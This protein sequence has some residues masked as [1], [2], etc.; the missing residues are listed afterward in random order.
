MAAMAHL[1]METG[2]GRATKASAPPTSRERAR[3]ERS[4]VSVGGRTAVVKNTSSALVLDG[5]NVLPRVE[6]IVDS[7]GL[8]SLATW[9]RGAIRSPVVAMLFVAVEGALALSP[10]HRVHETT[11]SDLFASSWIMADEMVPSQ[12][13]LSTVDSSWLSRRQGAWPWWPTGG[14]AHGRVDPARRARR[15]A[16]PGALGLP[17]CGDCVGG[18]PDHTPC[19]GSPPMQRVDSTACK[20]ADHASPNDPLTHPT[21]TRAAPRAARHATTQAAA[22]CYEPPDRQQL[23]LPLTQVPEGR[24]RVPW[25]PSGPS[26]PIPKK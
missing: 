4:I 6:Q 19:R 8:V 22:C 17:R 14:P 21:C 7:L 25:R 1:E 13:A 10:A 5:W 20:M 3:T 15:R 16:G 2:P 11:G 18:D 23:G 26:R 9:P 24:R 12:T